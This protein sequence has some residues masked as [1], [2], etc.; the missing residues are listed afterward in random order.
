[1]GLGSAAVEIGTGVA[2]EDSSGNWFDFGSNRGF[3]NSVTGSRVD[4]CAPTDVFDTFMENT[5]MENTLRENLRDAS[6]IDPLLLG[7]VGDLAF[8]NHLGLLYI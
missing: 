7:E 4:R 8:T 3:T 6:A 2:F 5:L 1:M